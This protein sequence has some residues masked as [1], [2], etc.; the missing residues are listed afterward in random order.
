MSEHTSSGR[1]QG[2]IAAI[3]GISFALAVMLLARDLLVPL[4]WSVLLALI[5][6]PLTRRL[7]KWTGHRGIAVILSI[8]LL[9]III[10]GVLY[11]LSIQLLNL[12]GEVPLLLRKLGSNLEKLRVFADQKLGL[13][14]QDQPGE[15]MQH[16]SQVLQEE[17]RGLGRRLSQ[18]IKTVVLVAIVPIYIFFLLYYR[19]R[20][21]HFLTM[22]QSHY[23]LSYKVRKA[24]GVVQ[25]YLSGM[26]IVTVIVALLVLVAFLLMGVKHALFFALLV[27]V[28][29]LIPYIGVVTASVVSILYVFI[30]KDSLLYPVLTLAILWGIQL[31][32]NNIITPYIV[33]RQVELNPLAVILAIILGGMIWGVSGMVLF[34][35]LLGGLK[36]IFDETN[37]LRPLGYLL[38]DR[39]KE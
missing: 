14:Y 38:G 24:S 22:W 39:E 12:A 25:K 8:L 7:E 20:F 5:I 36:V 33:G 29:N 31:I 32:E 37:S 18:T 13:P 34:I 15:L 26:L 3:L 11:L 30:T 4:C 19:H 16:L 9:T 23:R 1:S 2:F 17:L 27:A 28:L 6:L 35:P 21:G 10:G